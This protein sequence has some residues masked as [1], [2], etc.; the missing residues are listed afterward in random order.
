MR[1]GLVWAD[2]AIIT[3]FRKI[4]THYYGPRK[5]AR[6]NAPQLAESPGG[7]SEAW[8]EVKARLGVTVGRATQ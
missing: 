2:G 1:N 6:R 3:G 8:P 5:H 7:L 4:L